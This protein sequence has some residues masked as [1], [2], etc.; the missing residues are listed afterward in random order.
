MR[1]INFFM[2]SFVFPFFSSSPRQKVLVCY[3][4]FEVEKVQGYDLVI[5]ESSFF[6]FYE[7]AQLKK[8]NKKVV[9]Y[10]SL[11]EVNKNAVDYNF[12]K[13]KTL[14]NNTDW[15]SYYLDL[16]SEETVQFLKNKIDAILFMG[17]D[18][19]FLDNIDNFC[20]FGAQKEHQNELLTFID[21]LKIKH[22]K[23]YIV[24]NAGLELVS[25]TRKNIDIILIESVITNF[26]FEDKKYKIREDKEAQEYLKK[27][28][29]I[30]D[31]SKLPVI[32]LE[33]S[34]S[35]RLNRQI[36]KQANKTKHSFLISDI[37][38]QEL[39]FE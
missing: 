20:A 21:A 24:Q 26:T 18:G 23:S 5:V 38:L 11:G 34:N 8:N 3:G 25:K 10:I 7:V 2:I 12:F 17:Y 31:P 37:N 22:P 6:N 4:K 39:P 27:I 16:T 32:L 19:L 28:D 1:L 30:C 36:L 15:D 14:G 9:A 35:K 13:N 29:S 33:Y